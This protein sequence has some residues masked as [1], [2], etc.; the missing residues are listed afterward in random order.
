MSRDDEWDLDED[1]AAGDAGAFTTIPG[2]YNYC[3]AW[4]ER[5]VFQLRCAVFRDRV[6]M[7][8]HIDLERHAPPASGVESPPAG[9]QAAAAA[10]TTSSLTSQAL[11]EADMNLDD[12][13]EEWE[14]RRRKREVD[15]LY[16]HAREYAD[17]ARAML[18][19]LRADIDATGDALLQAGLEAI[20][21]HLYAIPVKVRRALGGLHDPIFENEDDPVQTDYNGT[22]KLV[23]LMIAESRRAWGS[24]QQSPGRRYPGRI[25]GMVERLGALDAGMANRFPR[26]MEFVRPGFDEQPEH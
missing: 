22:A 10:S 9:G 8:A 5:C 14:A 12:D 6:V 25:A 19:S 1:G 4:C 17:L 20:Q 26:A 11:D 24:L 7:E 15:P 18:P 3:D 13:T 23:R 2:V 16:L 21:W